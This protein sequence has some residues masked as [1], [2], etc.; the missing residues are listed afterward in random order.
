M[1]GE[2]LFRDQHNQ[3]LVRAGRFNPYPVA[4]TGGAGT[5]AFGRL[6][7]SNPHTAYDAKQIHDNLPLFWDDQE[8]SGGGTGSSHSAARASSIMS[9]GA[10]TAG[11]RVRQTFMRFNY[12]PGKSLLVL[13]TGIISASGGGAGI[14][15]GVGY[16][17]DNNGLFWKYDGGTIKVVRRSNVTGSP[18]D[19][20]VAQSAWNGDRLDGTGPSGVT[21][22]ATAAQIMWLDMEW[23][24]VG[25]ARMGF[26]ID[27]EFVL[28]HTFHHAN[29]VSAVYMSTPNLPLRYEIEN[30]GTGAASTLEHICATVISEGGDDATGV[31]RAKSSAGA[32]LSASAADTLYAAIGLRLK[33]TYSGAIII[34]RRIAV[35]NE[36][37]QDFEWQLLINPTVAST[38][39]YADETNSAVQTVLGATAN[40]V[41]GGTLIAAGFVKSGASTGAAEHDIAS[42]LRVGSAID[43]TRDTLVLAVRPLSAN[44]VIQSSLQ[45]R[46][47]L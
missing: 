9:V 17:D 2:L 29:S 6:R 44:A 32:H 22:D 1:S 15:A 41:T 37:T 40:T 14:T 38:F 21:L 27:G 19:T 10:T 30:D 34:P 36:S 46:E 24:G 20:E 5:D 39:T 25:T 23:L 26:V 28:C 7:V 8:T 18:V 47:I 3:A 16:F 45:W 33:A 35:M 12:Q 11:K 13:L 42:A 31:L 43:G 4:I